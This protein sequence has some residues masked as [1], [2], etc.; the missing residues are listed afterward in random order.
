MNH[1]Y[2][3]Y[4][5]CHWFQLNTWWFIY[6]NIQII[7]KNSVKWQLL[8]SSILCSLN[9]SEIFLLVSV[10]IFYIFTYHIWKITSH[11]WKKWIDIIKGMIECHKVYNGYFKCLWVMQLW[12]G[13]PEDRLSEKCELT[14]LMQFY[15][16][17]YI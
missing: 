6:L 2:H 10:F 14:R 11:I 13:G 1:L 15:R 12:G 8:F 3:H 4:H 5:I 16:P 7:Q 17:L 9:Y